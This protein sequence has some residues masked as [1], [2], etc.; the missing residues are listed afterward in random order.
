MISTMAPA[1]TRLMTASSSHPASIRPRAAHG[2][3]SSRSVPCGMRE[4]LYDSR[5]VAEHITEKPWRDSSCAW[6]AAGAEHL[7]V[8]TCAAQAGKRAGAG[9][10][11]DGDARRDCRTRVVRGATALVDSRAVDWTC[12]G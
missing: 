11:L 7:V 5:G 8:R 12:V 10:L 9:V 1:T 2:D 4:I 3:D 6:I